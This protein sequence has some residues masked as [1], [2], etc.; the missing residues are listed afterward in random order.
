MQKKNMRSC[1]GMT[2]IQMGFL[3]HSWEWKRRRILRAGN[4]FRRETG[5]GFLAAGDGFAVDLPEGG[6]LLD[7][8]EAAFAEGPDVHQ[9]LDEGE[10]QGR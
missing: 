3:M 1:G 6:V 7:Q 2:S 4:C 5:R 8:L 9:P 10:E